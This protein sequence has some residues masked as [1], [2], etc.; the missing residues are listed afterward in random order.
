MAVLGRCR[1]HHEGDG[2]TEPVELL[3]PT[4]HVGFSLRWSSF[5]PRSGNR[6]QAIV[7]NVE[8]NL[9]TSN[10]STRTLTFPGSTAFRPERQQLAAYGDKRCGDK[11]SVE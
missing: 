5:G 1:N 6:T 4:K 2:G 3:G 8:L 9:G 10:D 11:C 7:Q